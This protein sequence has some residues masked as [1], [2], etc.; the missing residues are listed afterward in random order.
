MVCL[1]SVIV[2]GIGVSKFGDGIDAYIVGSINGLIVSVRYVSFCVI[3][4]LSMQ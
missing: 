3:E 2:D 1:E 4:Q